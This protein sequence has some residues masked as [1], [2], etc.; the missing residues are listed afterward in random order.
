MGK[1]SYVP[2]LDTEF[3][4]DMGSYKR[5]Y[6]D[7]DPLSDECIARYRRLKLFKNTSF[8]VEQTRIPS[9]RHCEIS[10]K[11]PHG[12]DHISMW[13]LKLNNIK[14]PFFM[15]EPSAK[16]KF[17]IDGLKCGELPNNIAPYGGVRWNEKNEPYREPYT[18]A[19]LFV[20]TAHNRHLLDVM[21]RLEARA[22]LEP[23]F[24]SVTAKDRRNAK[25]RVRVEKGLIVFGGYNGD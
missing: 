5:R 7:H 25:K 23:C 11:I 3:C 15:T 20:K 16:H 19:Y 2:G 22:K 21:A 24:N 12:Y 4:E 8:L 6:I 17:Q 18:S 10:E 14:I 13:W 1:L 9:F